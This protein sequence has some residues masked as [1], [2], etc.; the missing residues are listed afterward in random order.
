[1]NRNM[2]IGIAVIVLII[3]A[4]VF[5]MPGSEQPAGDAGA[6]ATPPATTDSAPPATTPPAT[7]A[8]SN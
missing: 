7:P 6:P 8:P 2:L 3:L 1:M 5:L 4:V